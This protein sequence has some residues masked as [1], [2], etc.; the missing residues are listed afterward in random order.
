MV[1]CKKW[2]SML[3]SCAMVFSVM[4]FGFSVS[5]ADT[6]EPIQNI[7]TSGVFFY[8]SFGGKDFSAA[9]YYDDEYFTKDSYEYQDSLATMTLCLAL[10]AFG[11]TKA[12][13]DEEGYKHKSMNLEAAFGKQCFQIHAFVFVAFLIIGSLCASECGKRKAECHVCKTVLIFK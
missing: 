11:S 8:P 5:A 3:L 1:R 12:A 13:N 9:Y 7:R 10:S 4:S 6:E 2:L